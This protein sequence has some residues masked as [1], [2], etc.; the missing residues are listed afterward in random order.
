MPDIMHL[1]KIKVLPKQVYQALTTAEGIRNWWTRDA[2]LD[3]KIGGTGEFRFYE[4]QRVTKV[5]VDELKPPVHVGWATISSFHLEWNG[6]R[7]TF[8]LR[9]EGSNTVL[10][11]AHRGFKEAGD[12]Y[13]LCTTG[14]G[15]Y[16]VSLQQ[17][18]EMG[19]GAPSPDIDF[20]RV[21]RSSPER[22]AASRN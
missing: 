21:I 3:S 14:W 22:A 5:R 8:D 1:I 17:Y 12:I 4:G 9:A 11:F 6:T 15:Y 7:I 20:A 2:D 18:L 16:L 19:V 10:A 13:A